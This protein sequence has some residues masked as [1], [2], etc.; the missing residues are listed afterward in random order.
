M[1]WLIVVL[2]QRDDVVC[3][4]ALVTCWDVVTH[5]DMETHAALV[6]YWDGVIHCA[7]LL[8]GTSGDVVT[9]THGEGASFGA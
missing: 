9:H 6:T 8:T 2:T 3:H 4:V 5:G 7:A 1:C